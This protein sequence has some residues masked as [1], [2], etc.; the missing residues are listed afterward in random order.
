[1]HRAGWA[2]LLGISHLRSTGNETAPAER[3]L[4]PATDVWLAGC[5]L[6]ATARFK[7]CAAGGYS[8]LAAVG[9]GFLVNRDALVQTPWLGA[10]LGLEWP[11]ARALAM[12]P[13]LDVQVPLLHVELGIAGD[14]QP[15]WELPQLGLR[16]AWVA[17]WR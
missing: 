7:A 10:Q 16:L 11:V 13:R 8:W 14:E 3:V 15:F 9:R 17:V 6:D 2:A 12:G 4:A 5:W 1:M